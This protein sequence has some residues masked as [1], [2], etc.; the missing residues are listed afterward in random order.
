LSSDSRIRRYA[1]SEWSRVRHALAGLTP[2]QRRAA[3][4]LI[5]ATALVLL[6]AWV[7][8]RSF[9]R[10]NVAQ[11]F[12][13]EQI[14][15]ASWG[16]WFGW[17]G[18]TGFIIPVLIL[19]LAFRWRPAQV[20]IGLGDWK[21]ASAI[22]AAY[23]P[24]VAIGT[25]FLSADPAFMAQYPH[26][27]QAAFD[28]EVFLIYQALFLLYWIG[29]EYLWR[30][31]VLFG[32]APAFGPLIAIVVQAM[33]FALLHATKPPAEAYLSIVGGI[34]LGALVWRCRS[35]WIAVPIHW[36]QM[37]ILDLWCTLRWRTSET[38][39]GIEALRN[40][41]SRPAPPAETMDVLQRLGETIGG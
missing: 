25:W 15:L 10:R 12:T 32:T 28:W 35:F 37:F 27:R 24:L 41:M 13:E 31:F 34:L 11:M 26:L 40:I 5:A 39:I 36:A 3:I 1:R 30:G 4:V 29:W 18:I 19:L 16:W 38:G 8:S 14:P 2:A 9:F 21:L 7:G 23:I 17:Q 33:P 22:A 6:Q 20:G